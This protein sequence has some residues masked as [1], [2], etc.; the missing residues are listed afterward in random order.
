VS[1]FRVKTENNLTSYSVVI[2]NDEVTV[3]DHFKANRLHR[4]RSLVCKLHITVSNEM[5]LITLSKTDPT[6]TDTL[7]ET[8]ACPRI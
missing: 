5:K 8:E 2:I 6:A 7:A 4:L 1:V 3:P